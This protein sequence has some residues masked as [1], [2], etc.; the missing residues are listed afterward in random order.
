MGDQLR[1]EQTGYDASI[2]AVHK[3][4]VD[5]EHDAARARKA[6]NAALTRTA[7]SEKQ[8]KQDP[9]KAK[10]LS[11]AASSKSYDTVQDGLQLLAKAMHQAVPYLKDQM[12][13]DPE[14][15]NQPEVQHIEPI[16]HMISADATNLSNTL[17][18]IADAGTMSPDVSTVAGAWSV[19][20]HDLEAAFTWYKT[21]GG[22]AITDLSE[23]DRSIKDM[24]KTV[25]GDPNNFREDRAEP[26]GNSKQ[27]SDHVFEEQLAAAN[28]SLDAIAEGSQSEDGR[29]RAIGLHLGVKG[30]YSAAF[31]RHRALVVQLKHRV[32]KM[33]KDDRFK[34]NTAISETA[35]SLQGALK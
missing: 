6:S 9:A 25:H 19:C 28:L 21:N 26:E 13:E 27:M 7:D 5:A 8:K 34:S 15:N 4:D 10:K 24:I 2:S 1:E 16:L 33:L 18:T 3:V 22:T 32:D 17:R 30:Q 31:K 11:E 29:L 20:R 14:R 12:V 35:W 23:I